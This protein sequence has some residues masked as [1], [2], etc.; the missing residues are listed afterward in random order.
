MFESWSYE[1]LQIYWWVVV[2]VVGALFVFMMFVQGGQTMFGIAKTE[3][4]KTLLVNALG[5]K[6]ELTFTTLVLFGGALF[7]AFPLFYAVSF[8]GAYAV[9]M[10]ILFSFTLQAVSYEY[11][12]KENNFLGAKIYEAFLFINGTVGTILIVAAIATFF[13]GSLFYVDSYNLSTWQNPLRGLEAAFIPFNLSMAFA[14]FFLTRVNAAA[15]FVSHIEHAGLEERLRKSAFK[16]TLISLP[17][18][19]FFLVS[20]FTMDG[21]VLGADKRVSI[22][23]HA[24]LDALLRLG[25]FGVGL[26]ALGTALIVAGI[27]MLVFTKTKRAIFITG[28]GTVLTTLSLLFAAGIGGAAYYPSIYDLQSSLSIYN[29]S[30][31]RYTLVVMSY[32]SLLIPF[33]LGYIVY[34][35]RLID[36]KKLSLDSIKNEHLY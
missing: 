30:G 9:W 25:V 5:K 26:L 8:G 7:A 31:S 14:V 29:S 2:S 36:S 4:E 17:F 10:A 20:L 22:E 35:W 6:W 1:A 28:L 11:R 24:Y 15:Y 21:F 3:D 27:Y 13:S 16:C 12:K 19:L 33:V 23:P 32:V 34:V 18:L